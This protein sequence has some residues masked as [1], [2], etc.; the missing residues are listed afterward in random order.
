[1]LQCSPARSTHDQTPGPA[2]WSKRP[3]SKTAASE[4]AKRNQFVPGPPITCRNRRFPRPYVEPLSDARTPMAD[5]F[6]SLLLTHRQ[7]DGKPGSHLLLALYG[8]GALMFF[9]DPLHHC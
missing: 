4:E 8:N 9:N 5:F 3:S 6:N 1:M 2:G 7:E